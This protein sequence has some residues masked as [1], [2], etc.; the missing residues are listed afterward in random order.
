MFFF[1]EDEYCIETLDKLGIASEHESLNLMTTQVKVCNPTGF[2]CKRTTRI[3]QQSA[4]TA[5]T[6]KFV[7]RATQNQ[8][9][10]F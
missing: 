10:A 4:Q 1:I 5:V 3:V 9:T 6:G 2:I 7:I 8:L